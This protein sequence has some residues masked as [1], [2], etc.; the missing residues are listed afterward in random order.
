MKLLQIFNKPAQSA[1]QDK[2]STKPWRGKVYQAVP[3]K[4]TYDASATDDLRQVLN[5]RNPAR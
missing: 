5:Q 3:M 4:P 2:T 1:A